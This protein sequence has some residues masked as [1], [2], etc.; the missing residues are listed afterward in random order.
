MSIET[1]RRNKH[2]KMDLKTSMYIR[3][4]HQEAGITGKA[5]CKKFPN[6]SKRTVYRHATAT[7]ITTEDG[8]RNNRGRPKKLTD[9]DQ[10]D[11]FRTLHK[12]RNE[13]ATFSAKKIQDEAK[14]HH[15][16]TKTI[17]RALRK[18]NYY[19]RQSRKK[20]L[21]SASDK[22]KRL[23]FARVALKFDSEFWTKQITFYLDGVSFSHKYNPYAEARA[24]S[25]MAW[26]KPGEGL[27]ITTKGRKE[28]SG[29]RL[30]NF[31]VAIAYGKGVVLCSQYHWQVTGERFAKFIENIFPVAF[32]KCGVHPNGR[33]WLQDGDP[34]QVSKAAKTAWEHLGSKHFEIPARSPD[35]NPIENM[36]HLV[37]KQLKEDALNL[38]ITNESYNDFSKRVANTLLNIS[39]EIIDKTIESMRTRMIEIVKRK[40][41]RTRF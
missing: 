31:Y 14:L 37:R 4:L 21:L 34:R 15:V 7:T 10:R 5:L 39:P 32:E 11:I 35:I 27:D 25:S 18:K 33:L 1:K 29:G 41:G 6:Y 19:Y 38:N 28:G 9:R 20:G 8:R 26:R 13:K 30:A 2:K 40:G 22:A 3:V 24:V 12:L 36:F 23:K 17:H 16:S